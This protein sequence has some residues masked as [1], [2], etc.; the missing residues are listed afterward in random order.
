VGRM[1][2]SLILACPGLLVL[3]TS[4]LANTSAPNSPVTKPLRGVPCSVTATLTLEASDR[5]MTY[6]GGISCAGGV[7]AK[8]IDVVPQVFNVVNGKS[9]W[10]NLS[11]VGLYQGPTP[12]NPLRL[13][14]TTAYVPSHTYRLLVFGRVTLPDGRSSS[15][16]VCSA[17]TGSPQLTIGAS[18]IFRAQP[19]T[20]TRVNGV[21][22][23][24]GQ[25]GLIFTLVNGSYVLN[26]GGVSTCGG[27]SPGTRALT[28]CAQ[29]VNHIN[30]K[31]VWFTI[32]G[33]CLSRGPTQAN[34]ISLRTART[35]H[36]G[37]GYRIMASTTVQYPSGRGGPTRTATVYSASAAP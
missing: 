23:S 6:G 15:A 17:C 2:R 3:A 10:F 26:Y 14:G 27:T 20:T 8:T 37:H 1:V 28:I 16:T 11:L 7:G 25:N 9:L 21:P 12:I 30:G 35:A 5:T 29:V 32:S 4:A 33:S 36:L 19:P 31:D 18:S 24:V 13:T 34:P 22:C